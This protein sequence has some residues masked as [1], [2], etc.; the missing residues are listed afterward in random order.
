[1]AT[2]QRLPA[3]VILL[4]NNGCIFIIILLELTFKY[5]IYIIMVTN[6]AFKNHIRLKHEFVINGKYKPR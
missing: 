4:P 3:D 2:K 6:Q 5:V 1:M